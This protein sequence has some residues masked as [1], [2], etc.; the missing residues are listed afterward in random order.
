MGEKR[1]HHDDEWGWD[2]DSNTEDEPRVKIPEIPK[3][4][5]ITAAIGLSA[6]ALGLGIKRLYDKAHEGKGDVSTD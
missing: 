4:V 3:G 2:E 6:T 1:L 5:I